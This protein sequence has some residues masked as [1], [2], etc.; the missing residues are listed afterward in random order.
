MSP[1]NERRTDSD[2]RGKPTNTCIRGISRSIFWH[3]DT[4]TI[5]VLLALA[6][7]GWTLTIICKPDILT[8]YPY[9]II[10]SIAPGWLWALLFSL[11]CGG[12]FWR[13]FDRTPRVGWALAIN[14]FGLAL[15]LTITICINVKAGAFIPGSALEVVTCLFAAW[16]LIR[17]GLGQDVVTP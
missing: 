13:I 11:Y 5:R 6:S 4:T 12:V 2:R 8:V 10:G 7:L 9:Q 14:A 1:L 3:A 16:A 15:W 17:T